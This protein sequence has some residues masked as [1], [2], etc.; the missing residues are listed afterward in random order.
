MNLFGTPC[1]IA[2]KILSNRKIDL[3]NFFILI[4]QIFVNDFMPNSNL[5]NKTLLGYMKCIANCVLL[6]LL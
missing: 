1:Q 2:I 3:T 6:F 4:L 5:S